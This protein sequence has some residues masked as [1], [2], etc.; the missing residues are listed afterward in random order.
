LL[1]KLKKR[2]GYIIYDVFATE[3]HALQQAVNAA[4]DVGAI[5][6]VFEI[7]SELLSIAMNHRGQDF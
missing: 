6:A 2:K 5:R 3:F 7:D 1:L 4:L